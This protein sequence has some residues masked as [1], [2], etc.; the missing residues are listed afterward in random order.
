M[1]CDGS[2]S[3]YSRHAFKGALDELR[4]Y[5]TA[6]TQEQIR[7]LAYVEPAFEIAEAS[8]GSLTVTLSGD[9]TPGQ[10]DFDLAFEI[11]GE[12][13]DVTITGYQ[14][15]A[16]E[17]KAVFTFEPLENLQNV[18]KTVTVKVGY[19]G[20]TS[21]TSFALP[22]GENESPAATDLSVTNMSEKLG[23]EP[24]V[25]GMLKAEYT[26]AD[27]DNDAEGE[28]KYQWYMA[29]T[30]DGEYEPI[31]GI[32]TQ[33]VILL[34]KYEGKY[35]KCEITP[36]DINGNVGEAQWTTASKAVQPSEGNPLT[37]W[38]MEAQVRCIS[39]SAVRVCSTGFRVNGTGRK[40]GQLKRNLG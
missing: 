10:E 17:K 29:D 37:N 21:E 23:E 19:Q 8:N 9:E 7:E 30:P 16:S 1:D 24:H 27:E 35:L 20:V 15:E 28:T 40:M 39:S 13:T 4:L 22:A 5:D 6:L 32:H 14:F 31:Q 34:D 36:A 38:F 12:E 2:G 25:K 11:D 26:Y 3:L 33:T 18:D